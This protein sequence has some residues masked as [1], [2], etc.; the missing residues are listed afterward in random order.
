MA[1]QIWESASRQRWMMQ[2][3]FI[4]L[5]I[6]RNQKLLHDESLFHTLPESNPSGME[7]VIYMDVCCWLRYLLDAKLACGKSF[8]KNTTEIPSKPTFS[9][10][11]SNEMSEKSL[12][13]TSL[14]CRCNL[15]KGL[16]QRS[17]TA[18]KQNHRLA[19]VIVTITGF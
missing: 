18:G 3:Y 17:I 10:V 14:L 6:P 7:H 13:L 4:S 1:N 12:T 8:T 9:T 2:C 16:S 19:K 5:R 15:E 11:R